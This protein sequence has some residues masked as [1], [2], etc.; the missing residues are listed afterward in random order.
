MS[1]EL[2]VIATCSD[3]SEAEFLKK[4][5]EAEG[6]EPF[7]ADDN[8]INTYNFLAPAVGWIKIR[9]PQSQ[10][11]EAA[12]F[13]E[14]LRNAEIIEDENFQPDTGWGECEECGSR[15]IDIDKEPNEVRKVILFS[16]A[17]PTPK[18]KRTLICNKCGNT[19]TEE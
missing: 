7:I 5:L 19:W 10:A 11:Q 9:V 17:L 2:L 15:D 6:F 3:A 12:I 18:S 13:V 4:H 16:F 1:D 8:I 14:D